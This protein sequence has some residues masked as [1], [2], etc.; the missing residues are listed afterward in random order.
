[1]RHNFYICNFT[2]TLSWAESW[3]CWKS[4]LRLLIPDKFRVVED[5]VPT[6]SR[7][8]PIG[9]WTYPELGGRQHLTC[10]LH[11]FFPT[12]NIRQLSFCS[13]GEIRLFSAHSILV[14]FSYY[15]RVSE[16]LCVCISCWPF[17]SLDSSST[18]SLPPVAS[19]CCD[20]VPRSVV[21]HGTSSNPWSFSL[22][23]AVAASSCVKLLWSSICCP[24]TPSISLSRGTAYSCFCSYW[25]RNPL[26]YPLV[27]R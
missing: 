19:N 23:D 9:H 8:F 24:H 26:I 14:L 7:T 27:R 18:P 11:F 25:Y 22:V 10:R 15:H 3:K 17:F 2:T 1:M 16:I 5:H 6:V 21:V 4:P 20:Q 12:T 13:N